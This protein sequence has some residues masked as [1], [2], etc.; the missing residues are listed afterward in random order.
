MDLALAAGLPAPSRE[1]QAGAGI[2]ICSGFPII[3]SARGLS[4][5]EIGLYGWIPFLFADF[6]AIGG[7]ALSDWSIRRG[8]RSHRARIA[9]LVAVGCI[10]P[11]S[12]LVGFLPAAPIAIA[13]TCL[14]AFL[15]PAAIHAMCC[16]RLN[17]RGGAV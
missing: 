3:C 6:G 17:P 11:L 1:N 5:K 8:W 16:A 12:A 2:C 10:A 15:R 7:G 14:I 13:P 9:L 4:L